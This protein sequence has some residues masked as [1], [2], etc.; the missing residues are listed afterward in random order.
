ML[1]KYICVYSCNDPIEAESIIA[2]LHSFGIS[3]IK[4]RESAGGAYGINLGSLGNTDILVLTKDADAALE[5]LA[6]MEKGLYEA[7][8]SDGDSGPIS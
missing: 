6:N 1:D 4:S 3:A 7:D 2:F 8:D 5:I